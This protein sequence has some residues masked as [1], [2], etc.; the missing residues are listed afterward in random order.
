MP[1]VQLNWET[2]VTQWFN[3]CVNMLLDYTGII[4]VLFAQSTKDTVT[5]RYKYTQV[6]LV[7]CS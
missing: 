5:T 3:T 6:L 7:K 4:A 2:S 1:N